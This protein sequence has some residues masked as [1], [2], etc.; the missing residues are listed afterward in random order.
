VNV[1]C[2][3]VR[4]CPLSAI[5]RRVTDDWRDDWLDEFAAE[6][7]ANYPD[8]ALSRVCFFCGRDA[9]EVRAES[10]VAYISAGRYDATAD[11]SVMATDAWVCH[12]SCVAAHPGLEPSSMVK[13]DPEGQLVYDSACFFCGVRADDPVEDTWVIF[14]VSDDSHGAAWLSHLT[15]VEQAHHPAAPMW[16]VLDEAPVERS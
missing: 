2:A 16:R 1:R 15:C 14:S 6:G 11:E 3:S 8:F 10:L 5:L 9:S 12:R 7:T 4:E 13:P